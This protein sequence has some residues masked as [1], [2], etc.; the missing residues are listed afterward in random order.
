[1]ADFSAY[2]IRIVIPLA[3]SARSVTL[4]PL[5]KGLFPKADARI[6]YSG[7][8]PNTQPVINI[9]GNPKGK[10]S[11]EQFEEDK[12]ALLA[13][14]KVFIDDYMGGQT[15]IITRPKSAKK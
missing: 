1:M 3:H 4:E 15:R 14:Y 11:P 6:T 8:D 2:I 13:A 9:T 12:V 5:V 7:V 10:F